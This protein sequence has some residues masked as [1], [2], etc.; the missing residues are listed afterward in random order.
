VP[1]AWAIPGYVVITRG[2][3]AEL[4]EYIMQLKL[5]PEDEMGRY[6]AARLVALRP[7]IE[8]TKSGN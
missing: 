5:A 7:I 6:A 8:K 3:L 4:D 2:L 1:N